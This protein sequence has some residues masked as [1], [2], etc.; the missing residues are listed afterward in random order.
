MKYTDE[1]LLLKISVGDV[2]AFDELFRRYY[3]KTL[4]FVSGITGDEF[5]S[6]TIVHELFVRLWLRRDKLSDIRQFSNYLFVSSRHAAL[7]A[8]RQSV[9]TQDVGPLLYKL[10]IA[11]TPVD[12]RLYLQQVLQVVLRKIARMP[13]QRRRVFEMSRRDGMS[14]QEIADRLHLSRRTVENHI[15]SAL[16]ELKEYRCL[17]ALLITFFN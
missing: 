10:D 15:A 2:D 8:L 16:A 17:M 3:G 6:S 9:Q 13:P 12:E 5:A 4:A 14:N 1:D 11:D 7:H